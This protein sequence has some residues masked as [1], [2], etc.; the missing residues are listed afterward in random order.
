MKTRIFL[1]AF[2]LFG[3][4]VFGQVQDEAMI[5]GKV[6]GTA[7]DGPGTQYYCSAGADYGQD[8]DGGYA[9]TSDIGYYS[10]FKIF[11]NFSGV[12]GNITSI[13]WWGLTL[14]YSGGWQ[15]CDENPKSF[16]ISF[17]HDDAGD[18]GSLVSTHTLSVVGYFTGYYLGTGNKPIMKYSAT[19]SPPVSG[20]SEGWVA[21]Q[22]NPAG[23][24]WFLWLHSLDGDGNMI[25]RYGT[26]D[27]LRA[28]DVSF[29]LY[30][31]SYPVPLSKWA[32]Y[33]GIFLIAAFLVFR[34]RR[35][36]A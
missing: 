13:D 12:S 31:T 22:G 2:F 6:H 9:W 17:Y 10:G 11:D 32:I 3:T 14:I 26:Y 30:C 20:L 34:F 16:E 27:Y 25:Q 18:I 36:L 29:C 35:R 19:I 5:Q 15:I 1:F 28:D 33:I 8:P 24:C 7:I 23:S 4:L 21:I